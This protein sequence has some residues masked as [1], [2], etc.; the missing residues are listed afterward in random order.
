MAKSKLNFEGQR[1]LITG[2]AGGIGTAIAEAFHDSGAEL[3][4]HYNK[5]KEGA[6]KLALKLQTRIHLVHANLSNEIEVEKMFSGFPSLNHVIANA[7]YYNSTSASIHEMSLSQWNETIDHNLTASF[8]TAR[9]FFQNIKKFKTISPSLVMI[10]STAGIFG[11]KG[12]ADYASAKAAIM[13]GLLPTLKNEIARL[14][15]LGR[16]N[17]VAPGWTV[18]PMAEKFLED[19]QAVKKSLQTFAMT[20]LAKPEDVA[21]SVLYLCSDLAG[22]VSGEIL[23]VTGGME[24]RIL[25]EKEEISL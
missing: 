14:S 22:H 11:E 20:K 15:P 7:G 18:T 10:G 25:W 2:S 1:V 13:S 9:S 12:H 4:L 19:K 21:G 23:K 3:Y 5:S 17:V 8:L 6:E 24:G 16:V